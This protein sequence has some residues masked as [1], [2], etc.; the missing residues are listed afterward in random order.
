MQRS[1]EVHPEVVSEFSAQSSG[2]ALKR[3]DVSSSTVT[4]LCN[5]HTGDQLNNI[6]C[7]QQAEQRI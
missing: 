5:R 7:T 3:E 4:V 1:T 2:V 6:M